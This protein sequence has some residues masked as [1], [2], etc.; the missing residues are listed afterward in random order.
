MPCGWED[1]Q[2]TF[3]GPKMLYWLT[4]GLENL[5]RQPFDCLTS[6]TVWYGRDYVTMY[7]T[8]IDRNAVSFTVLL[9]F[10]HCVQKTGKL[11]II[12]SENVNQFFQR[13]SMLILRYNSILFHETFPTEAEINMQPFRHS[14]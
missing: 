2:Q 11:F 1:K 10:V 8:Y 6:R 5:E 9:I 14:F 4:C 7:C 3:K 12:I 13:V